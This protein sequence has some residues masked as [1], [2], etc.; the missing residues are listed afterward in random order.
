VS[1]VPIRPGLEPVSVREPNPDCVSKL[2]TLLQEARA[3]EVTGFAYAA[4]HP[5]DLTSFGEGGR[6]TRGML[7][8]LVMLQHWMCKSDIENG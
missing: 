2:E 4:L 8:A 1:I 5:G 6:S 7:G 3:G